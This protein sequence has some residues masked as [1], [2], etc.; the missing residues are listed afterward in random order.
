[1]ERHIKMTSNILIVETKW[2]NKSMM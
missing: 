2:I 1:V